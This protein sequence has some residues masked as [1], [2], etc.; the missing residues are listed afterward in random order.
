MS[1]RSSITS[2]ASFSAPDGCRSSWWSFC[3]FLKS[4]LIS[5]L[6]TFTSSFNNSQSSNSASNS[7]CNC[8]SCC[9]NCALEAL[10]CGSSLQDLLLGLCVSL[11]DDGGSPSFGFGGRCLGGG[12]SLF[13]HDDEELKSITTLS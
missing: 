13:S 10:C 9:C 12:G 4:L 2:C 8:D 3:H 11:A 7:F 6:S 1:L 5:S